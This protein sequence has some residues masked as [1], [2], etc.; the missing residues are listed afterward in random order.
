MK[1]KTIRYDS[2]PIWHKYE[3]GMKHDGVDLVGGDS[4]DT[5]QCDPTIRPPDH[6]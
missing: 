6:A 1:S 2:P 4:R 3:M 5:A